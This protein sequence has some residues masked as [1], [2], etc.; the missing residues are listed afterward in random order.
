MAFP[1]T[2]LL[3]M[4]HS[5]APLEKADSFLKVAR[6]HPDYTQWDKAALKN[7]RVISAT[8]R[9]PKSTDKTAPIGAAVFELLVTPELC[10]TRGTI[11]GGCVATLFDMCT[12][13]AL[14]AATRPGF[15]DK[16]HVSRNLNCSYLKP[17]FAGQRMR[18]ECEATALGKRNGMTRGV[19]R[20]WVDGAE[21]GIGGE[22]C[23]TCEHDK[24]NVGI[25]APRL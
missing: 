9:D 6:E 15:W 1:H 23:Y 18:I 4:D 16:G 25:D 19:F 11:H 22:V 13:M 17:I 12:S 21:D 10:N 2:D 7:L 20:R 5:L 8:V 24:V 3:E 14:N